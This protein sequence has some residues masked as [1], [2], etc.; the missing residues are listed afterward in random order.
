MVYDARGLAGK[1]FLDSCRIGFEHLRNALANAAL[2]KAIHDFAPKINVKA[3][4]H[5]ASIGFRNP[6]NNAALIC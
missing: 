1:Q 4:A 5:R 3:I 6:H 2:F